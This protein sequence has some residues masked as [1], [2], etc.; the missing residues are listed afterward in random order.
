MP[1]T[2]GRFLGCFTHISSLIEYQE[3]DMN[4]EKQTPS[5]HPKRTAE[6]RRAKTLIRNLLL[7]LKARMDDE[8]RARHLT[9]AQGRFLRE[10]KERP[11]SSGA[12]LARACNVTPQS[13]QAMMARAVQRGWVV[14]GTHPENH[15]LVTAR[16]TPAGERLLAHADG[17]LARLEEEMWTGVSFTQ[18]RQMNAVLESGLKNLE[19]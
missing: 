15:R 9:G 16:L 1:G 6:M 12:Q 19:V 4:A 2:P 14:R 8:L 3:A 18:L 11:G 17:I 5:E 7:A 10:V 13:A